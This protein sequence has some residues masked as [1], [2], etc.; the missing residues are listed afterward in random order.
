MGFRSLD[1]VILGDKK[2]DHPV[3]NAVKL[4][5]GAFF[6]CQRTDES[7]NDYVRDFESRLDLLEPEFVAS[8]P[9]LQYL[10]SPVLLCAPHF[11]QKMY[12]KEYTKCSTDQRRK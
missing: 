9:D 7:L 4:Y 2:E 12:G 11:A 3:V 1:E 10:M 5:Y 6:T 8:T